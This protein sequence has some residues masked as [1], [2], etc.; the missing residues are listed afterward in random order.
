MVTQACV[1]LF[2]GKGG[3]LEG[4]LDIARDIGTGEKI[5]MS[6]RRNQSC[7]WPKESG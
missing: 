1:L 3:N 2:W 4:R 7:Q 5:L 6:V